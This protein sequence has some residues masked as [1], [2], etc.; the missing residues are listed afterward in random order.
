MQRKEEKEFANY[1]S[2]TS[3]LSTIHCGRVYRGLKSS[4]QIFLWKIF[5]SAMRKIL[6]SVVSSPIN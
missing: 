4:S 5:Q 3:S 1:L 2:K 6:I